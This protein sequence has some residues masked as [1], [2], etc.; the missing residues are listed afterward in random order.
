MSFKDDLIPG[1]LTL[2][3][4]L[5]PDLLKPLQLSSNTLVKKLYYIIVLTNKAKLK[6]KINSN[7][8]EQNVVKGKRLKGRLKV[9]IGFL[10]NITR[11]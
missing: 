8:G 10:I 4:I 7:I 3:E 9:Y 5:K 11:D 6:K 2:D 1:L